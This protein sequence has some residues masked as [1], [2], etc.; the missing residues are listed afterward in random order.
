[1]G[2]GVGGEGRHCSTSV[3]SSS[4]RFVPSIRRE[5]SCKVHLHGHA[6]R[7]GAVAPMLALSPPFLRLDCWHRASEPARTL[8]GSKQER[9]SHREG[10][11]ESLRLFV[12]FLLPFFFF[13]NAVKT[14][15][16]PMDHL[17]RVQERPV[18]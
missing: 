14:T 17:H 10:E 9:A 2:T 4:G 16:Q 7:K 15:L 5:C 8:G 18:Y 6:M 13:F 1:M 3:A 12:L 11:E